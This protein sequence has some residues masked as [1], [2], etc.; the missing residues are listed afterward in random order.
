MT[1][2]SDDDF[3][4]RSILKQAAAGGVGFLAGGGVLGGPGVS[5]A[6]AAVE[7]V[8]ARDEWLNSRA[9]FLSG[10]KVVPGR[11]GVV[12]PPRTQARQVFRP[13]SAQEIAELVR[14]FPLTT[15]IACVC[16]A[17]ESSNAALF[18][19]G[20]A[21]VLDLVHLKTI[22]FHREGDHDLVTLGG[23][24]VFR[25]LVEAMK[26]RRVALPVGTGPTV[27]VVGYLV[28][29]GLSGY[30][31]RRLGLLAQRVVRLTLV[32][33]A[34]EVRVLTPAD[35]L[36]T[37]LLGAGGALGIVVDV[38]L[39]LETEE[40]LRAAEQRVVAFET[41]DQAVKFTHAAL[42]FQRERVLPNESVAME[43]VV[44]GGK[45]LVATV[46]FYDSF[47]GDPAE[48]IRPLEDLAQELRLSIVQ[49]S[50]WTTWYE[51]AAAL[52]PVIAAMKGNPLV[53]LQHGVGTPGLPSDAVLDFVSGTLVAGAPLDEAPYSIIEIRTLGGAARRRRPIPSGN[54]QQ[55]FFV[56]SI[57]LY[58]ARD[59][60]V[61]ERQAIA[62]RTRQIMG[63]A[64]QVAG[65]TVELSGTHSQP[66]DPGPGAVAPV[67]FGTAELAETVRQWKRNIDPTNRF[68]FHPYAR[69]L[70]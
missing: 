54:C 17:H 44:S 30:F 21:I 49:K 70:P 12:V 61:A 51:V 34:G 24:V 22:E 64:R 48:F 56:D 55:L 25:E 35:E 26:D 2:N 15:P 10:N 11:D 53:M 37:P 62:D 19:S 38:T 1:V 40:V 4:R 50:Q 59:K 45:V 20:E 68:R 43:L 58:D 41:R 32:T 65:L 6:E 5:S 27:G 28:N 69:L 18:A 23:G 33:A 46:V 14:S 16:G 36:F 42:R 31:S 67:I 3:S 7:E 9:H 60:S 52:W 66:D 57:T 39:Q 47:E 13:R 63:Q 8:A 29:G